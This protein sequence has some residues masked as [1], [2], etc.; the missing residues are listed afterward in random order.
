MRASA[1]VFMQLSLALVSWAIELTIPVTW[2]VEEE[3]VADA[4]Q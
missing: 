3:G 4:I 1:Y 2:R